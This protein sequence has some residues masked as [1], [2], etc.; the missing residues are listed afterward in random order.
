M[1]R[2]DRAHQTVRHALEK[3]GWVITHD[4]LMLEYGGTNLYVD[5]GAEY[6]LG[7]EKDGDYIAVEIK[8]FQSPSDMNEWE[9][10]LGQY[11]FYEFL[12]EEQYPGRTLFLA[13]PE[14]AFHR[15]FQ[16]SRGQEFIRRRGIRLLIF[17]EAQEEIKQWIL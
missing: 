17:L 15:V 4:P 16:D 11:L 14:E 6:P 13:M 7:A 12:L 3:E 9:K 2:R 8:G 1:P 5:L 10:A